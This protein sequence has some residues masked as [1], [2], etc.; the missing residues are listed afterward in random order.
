MIDR[1]IPDA[2]EESACLS[3]DQR[4]VNRLPGV[5]NALQRKGEQA[6]AYAYSGKSSIACIKSFHVI[7]EA[8]VK[9]NGSIISEIILDLYF[10]PGRCTWWQEARYR[11]EI[12][13][14]GMKCLLGYT[15]RAHAIS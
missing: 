3:P 10:H 13:R 5:F 1:S 9:N 4:K 14:E 15:G 11:F 2:D 12:I 6:A 8:R 7:L